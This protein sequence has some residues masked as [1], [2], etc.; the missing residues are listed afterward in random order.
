[1][2]EALNKGELLY[3]FPSDYQRERVC[4][5]DCQKNQFLS[6]FYHLRNAIA[7]GRIDIVNT[8]DECVYIFEDTAPK[9]TERKVSARMILRKST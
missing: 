6:V 9:G 1:M 3:N 2:E 4:I 5:F 8:N 7:H